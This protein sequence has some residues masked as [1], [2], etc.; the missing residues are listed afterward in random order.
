MGADSDAEPIRVQANDDSTPHVDARQAVGVQVG[1]ENTQIIYN[2]GQ[3]TWADGVALPPLVSVSGK[4]DSPYRGLRAFE[5]RD[6]PFFLAAKRP[7]QTS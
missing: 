7:P 1:H 6:A 2:Y 3:L 4:V 5:E